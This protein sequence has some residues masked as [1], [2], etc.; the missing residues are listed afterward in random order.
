MT[1]STL[2]QGPNPKKNPSLAMDVAEDKGS[3]LLLRVTFRVIPWK[4]VSTK[5]E[6]DNGKN[7]NI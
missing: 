7:E 3:M 6:K 4:G 2:G 5:T 1:I